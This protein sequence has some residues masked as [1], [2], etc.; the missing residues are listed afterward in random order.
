[1]SRDEILDALAKANP[2]VLSHE[3]YGA[4][5]RAGINRIGTKIIEKHK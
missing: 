2:P 1:M 5:K 4:N 3:Q